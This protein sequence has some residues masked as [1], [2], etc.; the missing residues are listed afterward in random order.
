MARVELNI[1]EKIIFE[2]DIEVL[3]SHINYGGHVGNDAILS[4]CQEA[5]IRFLESIGYTELDIGEGIAT[6][7]AD[8]S[9]RFLSEAYRGQEI[10]VSIG[11]DGITRCSF[12]LYYLLH[13][14]HSGKSIAKVST[15]IV[16]FDYKLKKV[17]ALPAPFKKQLLGTR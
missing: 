7:M 10:A 13:N 14:K 5:R 6:I 11:V 9:I 4:I 17:V 2:T 15:G 16:S 12:C 1:P 3:I 8:A